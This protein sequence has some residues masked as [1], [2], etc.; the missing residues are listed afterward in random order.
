M[1]SAGHANLQSFGKRSTLILRPLK[2][3]AE[4]YFPESGVDE[5]LDSP[6]NT[7]PFTTRLSPRRFPLHLFRF[8]RLMLP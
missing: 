6:P 4:A 3:R 2:V 1:N 5:A 8:Y 7:I